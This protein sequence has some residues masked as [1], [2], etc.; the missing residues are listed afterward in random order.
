M[1]KNKHSGNGWSEYEKLVMSKLDSHDHHISDILRQVQTANEHLLN[2]KLDVAKAIELHS[3]SCKIAEEFPKFARDMEGIK[4]SLLNIRK[5]EKVIGE[6]TKEI[7]DLKIG[8]AQLN[9]K[10]GLWGA[11][12]GVVSVA[13]IIVAIWV[14]NDFSMILSNVFK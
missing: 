4:T 13:L 10:S 5:E 6:N 14:K 2:F 12:G 3:S 7:G 8:V 1:T 9:V 11:L